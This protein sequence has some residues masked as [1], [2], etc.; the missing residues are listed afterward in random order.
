MSQAVFTGL[1]DSYEQFYQAVRRCWRFGQTNPVDVYIVTA[2]KEGD[3]VENILRKER[4]HN[5]MKKAMAKRV[6]NITL[7]NLRGI[8]PQRT[9]YNPSQALIM[10]KF[11]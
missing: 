1:S 7:A 2:Q 8:E 11:I 3:V 4:Q 9:N 6:Q 10:P 5:Q